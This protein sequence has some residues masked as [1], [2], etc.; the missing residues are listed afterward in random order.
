MNELNLNDL[1]DGSAHPADPWSTNGGAPLQPG[2][3]G[4][5]GPVGPV[6]PTP[7]LVMSSA[8]P[9]NHPTHMAQP[10]YPGQG[11]FS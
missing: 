11:I 6:G 1:G 4:Y 3:Y 8:G 7:P 10:P 5:G 9:N 2:P